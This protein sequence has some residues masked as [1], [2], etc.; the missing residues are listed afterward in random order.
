MI[1]ILIGVFLAVSLATVWLLLLYRVWKKPVRYRVM[2]SV[3]FHEPD[4]TGPIFTSGLQDV[5]AYSKEE[6]I[7][8]I[9]ERL[10]AKNEREIHDLGYARHQYVSFIATKIRPN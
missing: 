6:A 2:Y 1:D 5:H 10:E 8:I 9:Q 7:G 3:I 4:G